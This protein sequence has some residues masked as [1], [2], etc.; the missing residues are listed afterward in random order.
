MK[1]FSPSG[2]LYGFVLFPNTRIMTLDSS[3]P[4]W[5]LLQGPIH[6]VTDPL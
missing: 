5:T 2:M 4:K 3:M 1:P 6:F